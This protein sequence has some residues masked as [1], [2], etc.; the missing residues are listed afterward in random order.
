MRLIR[1]IG[2]AMRPLFA[3]FAALLF[4]LT[5]C[6]SLPQP[7]PADVTR[8]QVTYPHVTLERL[9]QDRKTYV[10]IC[11]GCHALHLP[12]EFPAH[13]WPSLITEMQQVQ[14]VQLS[15]EQRQQIEE[16]L[17]AMAQRPAVVAS[18]GGAGLPAAGDPRR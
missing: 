13:R 6:A 5:A 1:S 15:S 9:A 18:A 7:T 12:S 16:F 3:P 14:R 10:G 17:V 2:F 8:A 4:G 11:S